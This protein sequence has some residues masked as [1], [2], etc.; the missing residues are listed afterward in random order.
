[1]L[2]GCES[3]LSPHMTDLFLDLTQKFNW[4]KN[5]FEVKTRMANIFNLVG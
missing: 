4:G 2:S 5:I 1:M 3:N